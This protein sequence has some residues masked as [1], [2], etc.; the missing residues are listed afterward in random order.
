[1]DVYGGSTKAIRLGSAEIECRRTVAN[2]QGSLSHGRGRWFDRASATQGISEGQPDLGKG[3]EKAEMVT[4][5]NPYAG[6][7]GEISSVLLPMLS[8]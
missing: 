7:A 8:I 3:I 5:T 1:M 2:E 6:G 4:R